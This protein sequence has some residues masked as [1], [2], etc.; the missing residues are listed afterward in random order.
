MNDISPKAAAQE[1]RTIKIGRIH[2]KK[3]DH[4]SENG[5]NKALRFSVFL[6]FLSIQKITFLP[7][8]NNF[9]NFILGKRQYRMMA[10]LG[11]NNIKYL[12]RHKTRREYRRL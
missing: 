2:L 7:F 4:V 5:L 3:R 11:F 1:A 9:L 12:V 6:S 8:G 10:A